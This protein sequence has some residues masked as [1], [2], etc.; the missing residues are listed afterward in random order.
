MEE[1]PKELKMSPFCETKIKIK[2]YVSSF[3]QNQEFCNLRLLLNLKLSGETDQTVTDR[4]IN[5][6]V[7]GRWGW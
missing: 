1:Q 2:N 3:S 7:G 5:W 4:Q 6:H